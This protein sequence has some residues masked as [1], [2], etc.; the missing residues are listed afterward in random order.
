MIEINLL[1]KQYRK[2]G[3]GFSFGKSGLYVGA[4]LN[5]THVSV[6]IPAV[7]GGGRA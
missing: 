4:G 3:H 6:D 7:L 2:S 5:I 1:P